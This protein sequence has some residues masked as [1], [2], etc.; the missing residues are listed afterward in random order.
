MEKRPKFPEVLRVVYPELK[1]I[2]L[3]YLQQHK[4]TEDVEIAQDIYI[5]SWVKFILCHR[6]YHASQITVCLNFI[7]LVAY[8][9]S[10]CSYGLFPYHLIAYLQMGL[11]DIK[12]RFPSI[13]FFL[14]KKFNGVFIYFFLLASCDLTS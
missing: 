5:I 4:L 7:Q 1:V 14:R 2:V 9:R 12:K 11:D 13:T 8:S 10:S 6:T 3:K